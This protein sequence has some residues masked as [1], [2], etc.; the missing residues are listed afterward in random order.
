MVDHNFFKKAGRFKLSDLAEYTGSTLQDESKGDIYIEDIAPLDKANENEISFL[1]NTKYINDFK[2]TK[3]GACVVSEENA[4]YAPESCV[5]LISK[6]PYLAHAKLTHRF[7]QLSNRFFEVSE[8]ANVDISVDI[9][10]GSIVHSGVFIGEGCKIGKNCTIYPN[11]VIQNSIIGD[12]VIIHPNS[13]IGQDGF[14]YAFDY[15]KGEYFKVLQLGRVIIEDDVE[16]GSGT[17]I[18][19][20][21]SQ[22]TIIGKGTKI[23][24]LVQIAHNVKIGKHC[25]I[26]GQVGISGS[27]EIGDYSIFAGQVGVAGH[28]KVGSK[29]TASAKSGIT[30]NIKDGETVGGMPATNIKKFHKQSIA[31]KKLAEEGKR[32]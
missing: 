7:Y 16:I 1:Q 10:E 6:N 27:T 28:L 31:L 11:A 13:S 25:A 8:F 23:D 12:N 4:K 18:D 15:D 14:G 29:V 26:A 19:R 30:K 20:G 17:A 5:L 24:N 3:A 21:S 22:D 9:G 32:N 2:E